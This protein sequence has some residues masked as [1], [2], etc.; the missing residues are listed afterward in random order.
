MS[1]SLEKITFFIKNQY[2]QWHHLYICLEELGKK[3]LLHNLV[4]SQG[5]E[6]GN[7]QRLPRNTCIVGK[8]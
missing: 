7:I 8:N 5:H 6:S 4:Q 1:V 2:K 3:Y